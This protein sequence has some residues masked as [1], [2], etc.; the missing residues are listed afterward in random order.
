MP[1]PYTLTY[2]AGLRLVSISFFLLVLFLSA[3][4]IRWI[5]NSLRPAFTSLPK[6]SYWRSVGL[7]VLW[8]LLFTI[9]MTMISG[10][11]E[12]LTPGAW[13]HHGATYRLKEVGK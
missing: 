12:L 7:V 5:W 1:A 10:A 3:V 13:E 2:L 4:A 9:I 8:G 6:L 11:R